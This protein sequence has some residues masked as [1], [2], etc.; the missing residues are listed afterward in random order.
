MV[1]STLA[2]KEMMAH[3]LQN[4]LD[5]T[6]AQLHLEKASSLAKDNRVKSLEEIIIGLGHDPK[7]VKGVESLNQEERRRHCY[8]EKAAKAT[9]FK[10]STDH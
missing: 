4:S 10:A 7:Y 3:K 8:L 9:S 5:N 2:D 6:A 1:S